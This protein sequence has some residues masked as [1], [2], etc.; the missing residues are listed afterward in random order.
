MK[1]F[2]AILLSRLF[3]WRYR[4]VII[5][6]TGN[7]GKTSTKEAIAAV[8]RIRYRVRMSGGNLNTVLGM[9]TTVIGDFSDEYYRTGGGWL[10]GIQVGLHALVG[11]LKPRSAYPE[12]LVLEYGA[13]RPRDIQRLV[14]RFRP[15][16]G[17]VTRIGE[18]P[19]HVEFFASPQHLAEEKMALIRALP[20]DGLAV[21]NYDDQT[22]L[23]MRRS[24]KAPV[25][26]FGMGEG[27]DIEARDLHIRQV[28][29]VPQGIAFNLTTDHTTMPV[30]VRGTIGR[31]VVLA[32]A[33]AVAIGRHLGIGLAEAAEVLATL[34][35][36]AGRM[37]IISGIKE[38]TIIDDTYNASP[39]ATHLA[40][41]AIRD[42]SGRKVLVMGDMRELGKYSL[43]AHQAVGTAAAI[44]ADVLV[45]VGE[46]ARFIADAAGNQMPTENIHW[47]ARSLEA[48]LVV[49]RLLEPG[50][51]VL[52]K[53]SQGMR[54]ERIVREIMAEPEH[55]KDLLVRQSQRWLE[56]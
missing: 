17:V 42:L 51:V 45:C 30:L 4:P 40:I 24:A 22:V 19:V 8:L 2:F 53:G 3:L 38:T 43:Q 26:T 9:A 29:N 28:G 34:R 14:R 13:D 32:A 16:I 44:I 12:I 21:L 20:M 36:P 48:A 56:K 18:I 25:V 1:E 47:F 50:D 31:G 54:M 35:V 41:D 33:A 5:G 10:F 27:A 52:V 39:A 46:Q 6:I 55:A 7:A 49:Q 23:D 11:W 15:T 37:R